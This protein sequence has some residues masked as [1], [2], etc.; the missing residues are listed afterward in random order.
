MIQNPDEEPSLDILVRDYLGT[1]PPS[2]GPRPGDQI[3][4]APGAEPQAPATP[5]AEVAP[6][7]VPPS[8]ATDAEPADQNDQ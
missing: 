6:V 5:Q 8:E 7:D 3:I 2:A 1:V 4:Y